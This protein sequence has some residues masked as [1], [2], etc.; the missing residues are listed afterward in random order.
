[1]LEVVPLADLPLEVFFFISEEAALA[2]LSG[3]EEERRGEEVALLAYE[4]REGSDMIEFACWREFF[5]LDLA[6]AAAAE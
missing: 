6:V 2:F 5:V 1:M 3:V 4:K